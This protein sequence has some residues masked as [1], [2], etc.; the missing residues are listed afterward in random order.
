MT[1]NKQGVVLLAHGARDPRWSGPFEAVARRIQEA[2]AALPVRL[3]YLEFMR[4]D[5]LEAGAALAEAGCVEI[6]VSPLFLG[7]GGHV[8]KDVPPMIERLRAL[9]PGV[10]WTLMPAIG[11][12]DSVTRAM[13][14]AVL[15]GL[16]QIDTAAGAR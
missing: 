3:A 13:A 11:E 4:P 6:A 16:G 5:L 14:D 2:R 15:Q 7:A 10:A 9:H 8:R 1:N 12:V